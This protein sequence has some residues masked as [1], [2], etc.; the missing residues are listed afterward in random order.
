MAETA[1]GGLDDGDA[2][3]EEEKGPLSLETFPERPPS[4]FLSY[5]R[6]D[7]GKII[8]TLV[9][10]LRED[11]GDESVFRDR[12]SIKPG[13]DWEAAIAK[14]IDDSD[15]ATFLIGSE[16]ED[17]LGD[18]TDVVRSEVIRAI[19]KDNLCHAQPVLIDRTLPTVDEKLVPLFAAQAVFAT[20]EGIVDKET[21][22]YQAVLLTAWEALR[23]KKPNGVMVLGE[24]GDLAP[25]K[26]I[27]EAM[28]ANRSEVVRYSAFLSGCYIA[29]REGEVEEAPTS[30]LFSIPTADSSELLKAR[31]RAASRYLGFGSAMALVGGGAAHMAA[32][33]GS[34]SSGATSIGVHSS[35]ASLSSTK[36]SGGFLAGKIST[37]TATQ[38][39]VGVIAGVSVIAAGGALANELLADP[40]AVDFA[41]S[42]SADPVGREENPDFFPLGL[43]PD[44]QVE[45]GDAIPTGDEITL[46]SGE[47]IPIDSQDVFVSIGDS[48]DDIFVGT[49]EVP[50]SLRPDSV[51]EEPETI[52]IDVAST[53][54]RLVEP[55]SFSP[56]DIC[57]ESSNPEVILGGWGYLAGDYELTVSLLVETS[58][59]EVQSTNTQVELRGP[60]QLQPIL[61]IT[62]RDLSNCSPEVADVVWSS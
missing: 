19:S 7:T 40:L 57:Y 10:N 25:L 12:D 27:V 51:A 14:A 60:V 46:A 35:A 33:F 30:C 38:K 5:R 48:L 55:P 21:D 23:R 52:L 62:G 29:W 61:D 58:G 20:S 31:V 3:T 53:S 8:K 41:S 17:G 42:S 39:L 6:K 32:S 37:A 16:W 24:P 47:T 18:G 54:L 1:A 28:W 36:A 26:E 4:V 49:V 43:P 56:E 22:E 13:S 15:I 9:D 44:A 59:G 45:L 11:L 2:G 34:S 50:R